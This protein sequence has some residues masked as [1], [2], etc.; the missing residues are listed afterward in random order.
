MRFLVFSLVLVMMSDLSA[1][2]LDSLKNEILLLKEETAD[3]NL[4]IRS[5]D[6]QFRSGI[7][8]STLGYTVTIA[9]GLMLGRSNDQLGQVLLVT[10]GITGVVGTYVLVDSFRVL[11]GKRRKKNKSRHIGKNTP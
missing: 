9:G 2:S 7:L 4:R 11:S 1:Q 10:G 6:Q 8:T 3:I 5:A